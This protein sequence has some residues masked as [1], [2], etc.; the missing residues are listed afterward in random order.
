[1]KS[2][3]EVTENVEGTKVPNKLTYEQ[4]ENVAK[5]LSTQVNQLYGRLQ[6]A[7]AINAVKRLDYLFKVLEH[8]EHFSIDFVDK[9]AKE[10]TESLTIPESEQSEEEE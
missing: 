2:N 4:L 6:E 10:I 8:Q 3:K 1:M 9:V 5:Q 7:E